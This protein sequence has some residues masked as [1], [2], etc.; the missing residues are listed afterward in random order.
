MFFLQSI[1]LNGLYPRIFIRVVN[2]C[3]QFSVDFDGETETTL[4]FVRTWDRDTY[5]RVCVAVLRKYC[6]DASR[7]AAVLGQLLSVVGPTGSLVALVEGSHVLSETYVEFAGSW[8]REKLVEYPIFDLRLLKRS[9][10]KFAS[11]V[12]GS[13]DPFLMTEFIIVKLKG[14]EHWDWMASRRALR[15]L[16][17]NNIKGAFSGNKEFYTA[18]GTTVIDFPMTLRKHLCQPFFKTRVEMRIGLDGLMFYGKLGNDF[19]STSLMLYLIMK[20]R[21]SLIRA[22]HNFYKITVNHNDSLGIVDCSLYT[23]RNALENFYHKKKLDMLAYTSVEYSYLETLEKNF[24][25]R[26]RQRPVIH[27]NFLNNAPVR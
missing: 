7:E 2:W 4:V 10:Q 8:Y 3:G 12:F 16:H 21:L 20:L 14:A 15:R 9:L 26:A 13:L 17:S 19:F 18:R 27:E 22:R 6:G 5:H 1:L 25:I 24:N 23:R 11:V